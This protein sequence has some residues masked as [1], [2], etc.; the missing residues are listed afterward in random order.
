MDEN[1]AKTTEYAEKTVESA[2]FSGGANA[3]TGTSGGAEAPMEDFTNETE[4]CDSSEE[5]GGN[6]ASGKPTQTREENREHARRRRA[7]EKEELIRKTREAAIIETLG[8]RNPYTGENMKDS[9]D[10]EEYLAMKEIERD[11][12]DP[13][14][15]YSRYRKNRER[16]DA[17]RKE[18]ARLK[19]EWYR[20]DREAFCSS[21]PDVNLEEL[22]ADEQFRSFAEGKVGERSMNEIYDS[23]VK[24]QGHYEENART[25]AAQAFA[26]Q[27]ASPGALG[28]TGNPESDY[29]TPDEVRK[30]TQSEVRANYEK[31]RNSMK[32]WK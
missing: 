27:K 1:K 8:G 21:H 10:V 9:L 29:F 20:H 23:F 12:G 7:M 31:I 17:K 11:G 30:M 2:A 25:M 14:A 28:S 15:D 32:K 5:K 19:E 16:S 13:V 4:F 22:I 3:D 18:E 24:F 26:N 6:E